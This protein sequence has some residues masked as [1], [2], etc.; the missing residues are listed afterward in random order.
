M[1]SSTLT[2]SSLAT[3]S[4]VTQDH[5]SILDRLLSPSASI[6]PLIHSLSYASDDEL[7]RALVSDLLPPSNGKEKAFELDPST[8]YMALRARDTFPTYLRCIPTGV[9]ARLKAGDMGTHQILASD[10]LL[11]HPDPRLLRDILEND[12]GRGQRRVSS[13]SLSTSEKDL[14]PSMLMS[15]FAALYPHLAFA[16]VPALSLSTTMRLSKMLMQD[17][18]GHHP[19]AHLSH[20]MNRLYQLSTWDKPDD[21]WPVLRVLLYL[22]KVDLESAIRMVRRLLDDRR[23]SL[24]VFGKGDPDHP[25]AGQLLVQSMLLRLCQT[26]SYS[27]R[28]WT[29]TK[30]LVK[31]MEDSQVS[32]D[33]WNLALESVRAV[34]DSPAIRNIQIRNEV[35]GR[36]ISLATLAKER[37][38]LHVS[39]KMVGKLLDHMRDEEVVPWCAEYLALVSPSK[40]WP[41]GLE[42]QH[43]TEELSLAVTKAFIP[44]SGQGEMLDPIDTSGLPKN[45][46][47]IRLN[48]PNET[49]PSPAHVLRFLSLITRK[50]PLLPGQKLAIQDLII[51]NIDA[52]LAYAVADSPEKPRI[53]RSF[54]RVG[55][56]W[57]SGLVRA[58][59]KEASGG[60]RTRWRQTKTRKSA[61]SPID[62]SSDDG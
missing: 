57:L 47:D 27:G 1:P 48:R 46:A 3:S 18:Q 32:P 22:A 17:T 11:V 41:K 16:S 12:L 10:L 9:Y 42:R 59:L 23:V 4:K 8:A 62:L 45:L 26:W 52:V 43:L 44:V 30:E 54:E 58:R 56:L 13:S 51:R 37:Q 24:P 36:L 7:F 20:L 53:T 31:T 61:D 29:V 2:P 14:Q 39:G 33:A 19:S 21:V 40:G 38:D 15:I 55:L 25:A 35:K 60:R 28:A 5:L 6:D 49:D 34:L 50:V